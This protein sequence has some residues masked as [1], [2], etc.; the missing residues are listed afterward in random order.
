MPTCSE[1]T[2]A[3]VATGLVSIPNRY[4]HSAVETVSL[5]DADRAADL[6]AA[7]CRGLEG[8]IGSAPCSSSKSRRRGLDLP[9]GFARWCEPGPPGLALGGGPLPQR[10]WAARGRWLRNDQPPAAPKKPAEK[11]LPVSLRHLGTPLAFLWGI[12]RM[13]CPNPSRI[14]E[15]SSVA[16]QMVFDDEA[17]QPLLAGVSKLARAR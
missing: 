12:P 14:R 15:E 7:F 10:H 13:G 8:S 6:L 2:R 11:R 1:T 17:R 9:G 4:M 5:D 16:K 3:G